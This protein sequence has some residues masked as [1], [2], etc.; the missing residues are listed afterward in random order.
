MNKFLGN[1]IR[2]LCGNKKGQRDLALSLAEF[3]YN[4]S[5]HR[6]T[7]LSPFSVVYTKT[8][9]HVID[10]VKLPTRENSRSAI[11]FG[12]N[13]SDLLKEIHDTLEESNQK[14]K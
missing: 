1:L 11:T 13:Y 2:C 3:A 7:G 6:S 9:T 8:P 14:Y 4:T 5:E 10:L 12:Y